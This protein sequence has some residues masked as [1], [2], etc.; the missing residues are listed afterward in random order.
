MASVLMYFSD[1]IQTPSSSLLNPPDKLELFVRT[2]ASATE[3]GGGGGAERAEAGRRLRL[4][5]DHPS[6]RMVTGKGTHVLAP[7]F[8]LSPSSWASA[9]ARSSDQGRASPCTVGW[10]RRCVAGARPAFWSWSAGRAVSP[11]ECARRDGLGTRRGATAL[12]TVP[13]YS[14]GARSRPRRD[15]HRMSSCFS[16]TPST[17]RPRRWLIIR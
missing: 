4:R 11:L 16:Q 12:P 3:R 6:R 17:M 1:Q 2:T 10:P 5:V 9:D 14:F 15:L 7:V 8:P 13:G